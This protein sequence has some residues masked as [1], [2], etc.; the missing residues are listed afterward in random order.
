VSGAPLEFTSEW[1]RDLWPA[2]VAAGGEELVA[3]S[4]PLSYLLFFNR[5]G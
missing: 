3:R 5:D 4:E 2:L 1:P